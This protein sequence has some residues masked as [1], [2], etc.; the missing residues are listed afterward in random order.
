MDV[1][2]RI[3][4]NRIRYKGIV[5]T[6]SPSSNYYWHHFT[7]KGTPRALHRELYEDFVGK[8]P[9]GHHIH[10]IDGNPEN[11]SINNLQCLSG[12]EHVKLYWS[13]PN[14]KAAQEATRQKHRD[15]YLRPGYREKCSLAQKNRTPVKKVCRL[16]GE[17]FISRAN[18]A[19]WCDDCRSHITSDKGR[20]YFSKR[21]QMERFGEIKIDPG[22]SLTM[23]K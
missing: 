18:N 21:W 3:D 16:C 2:E 9:K 14:N 20:K 22:T 7:W 13:D 10:H 15:V 17:S 1:L 12:P 19:K 8:I 11:N 6:K 5:W 4:E 23:I